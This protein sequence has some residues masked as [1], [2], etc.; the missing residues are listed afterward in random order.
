MPKKTALQI[1]DFKL[2]GFGDGR[3]EKTSLGEFFILSFG[4]LLF[5]RLNFKQIICIVQQCWLNSKK[6]KKK[7]SWAKVTLNT[8]QGNFLILCAHRDTFVFWSVR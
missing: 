1:C 2:F 3:P 5:N 4:F 8:G 7:R 6:A